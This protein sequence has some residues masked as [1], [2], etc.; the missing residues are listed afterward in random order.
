MF[1]SNLK[2]ITFVLLCFSFG[3]GL[4][5][6]CAM[7]SFS[8][9]PEQ[10]VQN[11]NSSSLSC[12]PK[13]FKKPQTEIKVLDGQTAYYEITASSEKAKRDDVFYTFYFKVV[14]SKCY[15]L[16]KD[17]Q[18]GSRLLYMPQK[19]AIEM[20]YG[21]YKQAFQDC[22]KKN[23]RTKCVELFE[24]EINLPYKEGPGAAFLYPEDV[25]ALKKLGIR[26]NQATVIKTQEEFNNLRKR[27][28]KN[29]PNMGE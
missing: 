13:G 10:S 17:Q 1:R 19:V 3:A 25:I 22:V 29:T 21:R 20:V 12:F 24:Q 9:D 8:K 5:A 15:Y 11:V 28:L 18:V 2:K 7:R 27:E 6:R 16:N 23:S 4:L 14:N 26:T